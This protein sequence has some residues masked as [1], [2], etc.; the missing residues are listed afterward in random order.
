MSKPAFPFS[1]LLNDWDASFVEQG[2]DLRDYFAAAALQGARSRI[3]F[4]DN[5]SERLAQWAYQ[6][7]DAMME[8]RKR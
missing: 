1:V 2:M 3:K 6:D 5:S 8:A 7:A 4:I